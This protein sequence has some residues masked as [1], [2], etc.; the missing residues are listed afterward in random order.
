MPRKS[1]SKTP[2]RINRSQASK[3]KSLKGSKRK[4]M[5]GSKRKMKKGSKRKMKSGNKSKTCGWIGIG[6]AMMG[7]K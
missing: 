4:M 3:R 5:K 7:G 6:R 2:R 1:R